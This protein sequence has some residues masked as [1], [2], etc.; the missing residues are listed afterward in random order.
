MV[1]TLMS[2]YGALAGSLI[3]FILVAGAPRAGRAED[4]AIAYRPSLDA[5]AMDRSVDPCADFYQYSC[6]GWQRSNPIPADQTAWSVYAKLSEDNRLLLRGILEQAAVAKERDPVTQKIGDYYHACMDAAA[7]QKL[8]AAPLK[9]DLDQIAAFRSP[10]DLARLLVRLQRESHGRSIL[11]DAS[12]QQDPDDSDREILGFDQAGLGLPDR[13]YYFNTDAKSR[14]ARVKYEAHIARVL[15]LLGDAPAAARSRAAGIMRLET[16][17]AGASL[18]KVERRDPYKLKNKMS[19]ASLPTLAPALAWS[20]YVPGLKAPPAEIVNVMAPA[21]FKEVSKQLAAQPRSIWKDYLRFH[22]ANGRAPYLSSAFVNEDFDFYRKYLKGAKELQPRWKRCVRLVDEQLGEALGQAFAR[23]KFTPQMREAAIAM[24]QGIESVME[25]RLRERDWMSPETKQA[26]LAKLH[27]IRNKIGYPDRWRDYSS[28]RIERGD[29]AGNV[30]RAATFEFDRQ[31]SKIGR[32]VDRG[33]WL[34][35]PPTVNAYFDPQMNDINFPA[36]V[37]QPPLYDPKLDEAPNY[38]DT[39]GTIGHEL[40]H[41]FDDEGSKFD[42]H[43]D[44]KNWWTKDDADK[45]EQRTK[46]VAD[47]YAQY[48]AV[49]E[50][51]INSALTLGE[52]VADLGG[53]VLAYEAW[54]E[55]VKNQ[56][57]AEREGLTPEQRFFV[58]FAQWACENARPEQQREWA[59]TNPHSPAKFRINGV[60]VNMPEFGQAFS[61]K[62][63]SAMTKPAGA[64]CSIW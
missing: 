38:G 28:V 5:N 20:A 1:R 53:E 55:A 13:D 45:F 25:R 51:H 16:A 49:D 2:G 54:K 34:M 56:P 43:G 3:F 32:P 58:G 31:L 10:E 50:L 52:D 23:E 41:G 26:A 35:S 22:L 24:V 63:G 33:E 61:C 60:V 21:F 39:G 27:A 64:A 7:V 11:F 8:G 36:G 37:L 4:P 19:T 40:T 48:V 29:F 6:G 44:L 47:Q 17:L 57:L 42:A 30:A 14:E 59:L 18:T 62:P 12:S 9:P 15:Q 46:C